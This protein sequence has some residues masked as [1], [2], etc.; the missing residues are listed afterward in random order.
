MGHP[1]RFGPTLVESVLSPNGGEALL[2]KSHLGRVHDHLLGET[3]AMLA[4]KTLL[5]KV[6]TA[7]PELGKE[8]RSLRGHVRWKN[9]TLDHTLELFFFLVCWTKFE[10]FLLFI[11]CA[12]NWLEN[13]I[14]CCTFLKDNLIKV[15]LSS[16]YFSIHTPKN[17]AK[18][19]LC[20]TP[21]VVG[22]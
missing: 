6:V 22:L 20:L 5:N 14:P 16:T 7:Y 15:F 8:L 21:V 2:S 17:C 10:A 9:L 18:S 12:I 11:L 3:A 4:T 19:Y 13:S 1:I